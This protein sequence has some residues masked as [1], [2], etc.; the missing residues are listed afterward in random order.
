MV[1]NPNI[2]PQTCKLGSEKELANIDGLFLAQEKFDGHRAIMYCKDGKNYFYSR[3]TSDITKEKEDNSDRLYY[4][5]NIDLGLDDSIFDGELIVIG[6]TDSTKVQHIL[7]STPERAKELWDNG[8]KL[9]YV[10]FD[11]IRLKGIDLKDTPLLGRKLLLDSQTYAK[12]ALNN[13]FKIAPY[14]YDNNTL[15][16]FKEEFGENFPQNNITFKKVNSYKELFDSVLE[17][18]GEGL[19]LKNLKSAYKFKRSPDWL[20]YKKVQTVDLVI[21]GVVNPDKEYTGKFSKE[22]LKARNY[23]YWVGD[24]PVSRTYYKGYLAGIICGAYK[25]GKLKKVATV[26]GFGDDIQEVFKAVGMVGAVVEV[27]YQ[28]IINSK[29]KSLRHP[30]FIRF[31]QDKAAEDCLWDDI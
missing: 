7:G 22:E 1:I 8:Y 10:I 26:K 27:A 24:E 3:R 20:K 23:P 11:I 9:R 16:F 15:N 21:M 12:F 18:N 30:R 14:Y 13:Y 28:D 25:D 19:V 31:R 2:E 29:T 5:H 17:R 4:L 6:E